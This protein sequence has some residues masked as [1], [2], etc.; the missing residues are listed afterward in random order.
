MGGLTDNYL[1]V[2]ATTSRDRWNQLSQV[3]LQS[4][5]D[6]HLVGVVLPG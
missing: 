1:R 2:K 4:A 6:G 5:V 3:R